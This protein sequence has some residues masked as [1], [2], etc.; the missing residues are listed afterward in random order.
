[1]TAKNSFP[2]GT[3]HVVDLRSDTGTRPT[4]S[5]YEAMLAAPLGDDVLGD[6]PSVMRLEEL[7]AEI[8]GKE[9]AVFVPSGTMGNQI[10]LAA[11]CNPGEAILIEQDAH[12]LYYEVG[13]PALIAGVVSWTLP[14]H[15]GVM[16]PEA[17]EARILRQNLHTP[18]TTLL[19]LE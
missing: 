4:E 10:A 6:D 5:M 12:I 11:H 17:I 8:T 1:M 15:Q 18:G 3:S 19:C 7:A 2:N 13:A 16:D 14:S 9:D